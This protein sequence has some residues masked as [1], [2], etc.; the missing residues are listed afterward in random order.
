MF[1]VKPPTTA[2]SLDA[3]TPASSQ[4]HQDSRH[5]PV[6]NRDSPRSPEGKGTTPE[7]PFTP[8]RASTSDAPANSPGSADASHE[9]TTALPRRLP[10]HRTRPHI[11]IDERGQTLLNPQLASS[12]ACLCIHWGLRP[13]HLAGVAPTPGTGM[14]SR[15][16]HQAPPSGP[17]YS[18]EAQHSATPLTSALAHADDRP[19]RAPSAT[20]RLELRSRSPFPARHRP[21][22]GL[23][24]GEGSG[25]QTRHPVSST[26]ASSGLQ[27]TPVEERGRTGPCTAAVTARG[28]A[29]HPAPSARVSPPAAAPTPR[30]R[31][32]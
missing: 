15:P 22:A 6:S 14:H 23:I 8:N 7:F 21:R 30:D 9:F 1:H 13:P 2:P 24:V 31:C 29:V 28:R 32:A 5:H 10:V 3:L 25:A 20:P 18:D 16:V 11:N 4:D 12:D 26:A 19:A 17:F 27:R